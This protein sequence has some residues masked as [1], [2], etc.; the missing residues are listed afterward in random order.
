MDRRNLLRCGLGAAA[1]ASFGIGGGAQAEPVPYLA[2]LGLDPVVPDAQGYG[3]RR[4]SLIN[5][6]TDE[7]ID[8]VYWENGR[9][10][11]D[12]MA[13]VNHVMRDHRNGEVH[14][15]H[16][17]LL[18]YLDRIAGRLEIDRPFHLISGYR[19]PHTNAMLRE[20]GGGGV[21]KRSLHMEGMASDIRAERVDLDRLHAAAASLGRGGVGYYPVSNFVH[22]DVGAVRR[23]RGV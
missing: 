11:P 7:R 16:G 4:V 1:A 22:V 18:D 17:R 14:Q 12:A 21:A 20:R 9:Y 8:A 15:I 3:V 5:T 19:S 23:W 10:L 13:E 2:Y 6:H